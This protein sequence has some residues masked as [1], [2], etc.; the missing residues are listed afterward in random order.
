MYTTLIFDWVAIVWF[1]FVGFCMACAGA[2]I[3]T[4]ARRETDWGVRF[5]FR[6]CA[7]AVASLG[8]VTVLI[9]LGGFNA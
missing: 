2:L 3:W 9:A 6:S 8:L 1:C 4:A 7:V 5:V